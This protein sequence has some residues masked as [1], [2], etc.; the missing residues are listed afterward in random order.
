MPS[1]RVE[2]NWLTAETA[3]AINVRE[4][5]ASR[6]PFGFIDAGRLD[7][8]LARPQTQFYY[9]GDDDLVSL[10]VVLLFAIARCHAF[11]QGNKRTGW[12][13]FVVFLEMNGYTFAGPDSTHLGEL[14]TEVIAGNHGE[15]QFAEIV[16]PHIIPFP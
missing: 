3:T 14:V 11:I 15:D 2:P 6:E 5:T 9:G 4:V 16:R 10:A 7:G 1:S 13:S 8:A 12:T